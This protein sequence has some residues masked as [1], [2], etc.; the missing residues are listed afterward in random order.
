MINLLVFCLN[1][2]RKTKKVFEWCM[3][4]SL[5]IHHLSCNTAKSQNLI[6]WRYMFL[7][8]TQNFIKQRKTK[9]QHNSNNFSKLDCS[10]KQA[11]L[12]KYN[13]H[14]LHVMMNIRLFVSSQKSIVERMWITKWRIKRL[15]FLPINTSKIVKCVKI[16]YLSSTLIQLVKMIL[17]V[18]QYLPFFWQQ[19][20]TIWQ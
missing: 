15:I 7:N 9:E 8:K 4:T 6:I 16:E 14:I 13:G 5:P 20:A 19:P 3:E 2:P 11:L 10:S 18:T 12:Y 1:N 17:Q